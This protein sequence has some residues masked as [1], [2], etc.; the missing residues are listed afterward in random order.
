MIIVVR[1]YGAAGLPAARQGRHGRQG[2][3]EVHR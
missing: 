3:S 1:E 2:S